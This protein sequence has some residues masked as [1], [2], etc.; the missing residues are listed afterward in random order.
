MNPWIWTLLL[1]I[2]V[3]G[4]VLM[5]LLSYKSTLVEGLYWN[6]RPMDRDARKGHVC[7]VLQ[8]IQ[9]KDPGIEVV[10]TGVLTTS[11]KGNTHEQ[12]WCLLM[13]IPLL[14]VGQNTCFAH[15]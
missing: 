14:E 12:T 10:K 5:L 1:A 15:L 11:N 9:D 7:R 6:Q 4:V 2:L 13:W 3:V 8:R